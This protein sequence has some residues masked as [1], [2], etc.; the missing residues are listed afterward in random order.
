MESDN[1]YYIYLFVANVAVLSIFIGFMAG[2]L[3]ATSYGT[4]T[5][6]RPIKYHPAYVAG[7]ELFR[8]RSKK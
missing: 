5:Y 3:S 1:N 2:A 7:C 6:N 4:C 8:D